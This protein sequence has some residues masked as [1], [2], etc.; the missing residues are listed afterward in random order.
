M[1]KMSEGAK[2]FYQQYFM[3][4]MKLFP[5]MNDYLQIPKMMY[6]R[7]YYQNDI[8]PTFIRTLKKFFKE[9]K[10]NFNKKFPK[11]KRNYVDKVF[12]NDIN[13]TIKGF[14]FPMELLPINHMFNPIVDYVEIINGSGAVYEIKTKEEY[15]DAMHKTKEF[16]EWCKQA[17]KNMKRGVKKGYV[18]PTIIA[19]STIKDIKGV[20][21]GK[22]YV[23]K[24]IKKDLPKGMQKEWNKVIRK[25]FVS[26]SKKVLKY[27]SKDY[28]PKT[29]KT[30]GYSGL[31]N[32]DK[33]YEYMVEINTTLPTKEMSVKKIH[34]IGLREVKRIK[35]EMQKVM[36][37]V[38]FKGT[39]DKFFN[40]VKNS[41]DLHY[42]DTEEGKEQVLIDYR[43]MQ[44]H[45]NK[46]IMPKYFDVKM[47][48]DYQIKAVPEFKEAS[49]PAAYYMSGD[50]SGKRKGTFYLN[51]RSV[52]QLSKID[53]EV[54]SLHEG[55]PGHHYQSTTT[56]DNPNI[57]LFIKAGGYGSYI[58]GWGLYS[59]NFGTY[60]GVPAG[61]AS[62]P[63]SYFGKLNFEM[64][65][66][67]RLVVDTG[68]HEYGWSVA[69]CTKYFMDNS[70]LP[71]IE[72][73]SEILRYIADP[74]QA[75][76]YKI[77]ELTFN[78]MGERFAKKDKLK[79]YHRILMENGP[80]PLSVVIKYMAKQKV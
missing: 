18:L 47:S 66:S 80:G 1:S 72:I 76:G 12:D 62:G 6:L 40:H 61:I 58:E 29:R 14:K 77:G 52:G 27:L 65:R 15:Q 57:P 16:A 3:D 26:P 38:K 56:N 32:G 4:L 11:K 74:G 35:G 5:T 64:M 37:D 69:K 71:K 2:K 10:K 23:N 17:V 43:K 68:I 22:S 75:L 79:E 78:K 67:M 59:E 54:L 31:P 51:M 63:L 33:L 13:L 34:E 42:K 49:A 9:Y 19:Q 36:K 53:V 7:K 73:D 60:D 21:E 44:E 8:S 70:A 20:L 24:N 41:K 48:H 30:L 39:L 45:I 28:L 55:N 25:Y 46:E 50:L